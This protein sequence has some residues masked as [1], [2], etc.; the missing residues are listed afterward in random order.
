MK[1]LTWNMNHWQRR[2]Q[3]EAGWAYLRDVLRPDVALVQ[4]A[5][6]P[7]EVAASQLVYRAGGI[8]DHRRWGSAVVSYGPALAE[9][10]TVRGQANRA[11]VEL[12]KTHP[13]CVA[14]ARVEPQEAQPITVV[15][16]YG[17]IEDGYAVTTMN[18][19]LSDLTPLFDSRDCKR[20][21]LAGDL[22]IST[23][24]EGRY[25]RWSRNC[26][27]RLQA[28]GLVDC[29]KRF[30][31]ERRRL[32]DCPCDEGIACAHVQ[33]HRHPQSRVPWNN[34]YIFC[35]EE[36]AKDVVSCR[37]IDDDEVWN[38]SDHAPVVAEFGSAQG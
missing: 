30:A 5:V 17:L 11:E 27:E 12:L 31:G 6:P 18:R 9:L 13:G 24:L 1:I 38:L 14:I 19:I 7:D 37:V 34:D 25:G 22:N 10:T 15:S 29:L 3:H 35:S 8:S 28:F 32:T 23:Q 16:V 20:I 33:T 36:L 4:E 21:V 26:L 2:A